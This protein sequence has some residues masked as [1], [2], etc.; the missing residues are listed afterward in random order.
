MYSL[1]ARA[2]F[3]GLQKCLNGTHKGQFLPLLSIFS[4]KA[5]SQF[6]WFATDSVPPC[7]ISQMSH[8]L[9]AAVTQRLRPNA[10]PA[11][12]SAPR[13]SASTWSG[14]VTE[15]PTARTAAMRPTAVCTAQ[16]PFDRLLLM[17]GEASTFVCSV[18][19]VLNYSSLLAKY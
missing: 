17:K 18:L 7:R 19:I 11:R 8:L 10:R 2:S 1:I 13:E 3:G 4:W 6:V 12:C 15:T 14:G 5:R 16:P 9:A